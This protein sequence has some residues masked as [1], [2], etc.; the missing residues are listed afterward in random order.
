M[1][2][3]E[4]DEETEVNPG[5]GFNPA[6]SKEIAT[7]KIAVAKRR[8]SSQGSGG[9]VWDLVPGILYI[10]MLC[11]DGHIDFRRFR[12]ILRAIAPG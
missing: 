7:R 12:G 2:E 5:S 4:E 1:F 3:D 11:T 6:S 8:T 9:S 10:D